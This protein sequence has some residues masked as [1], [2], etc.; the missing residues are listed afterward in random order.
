MDEEKTT[1]TQDTTET[2]TSETSES[3]PEKGEQSIDLAGLQKQLDGISAQLRK[4]EVD[5]ALLEKVDAGIQQLAEMQKPA[6]SLD[7]NDEL[8]QKVTALQGQVDAGTH[9]LAVQKI[10]TK[11][12]LSASEFDLIETDDLEK[13]ETRATNLREKVQLANRKQAIEFP[14]HVK[15][16][17]DAERIYRQMHS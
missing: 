6:E 2:T 12:N 15:G 3:T 1:E 5:P 9:A 10:V 11:H 16:N 7:P 17:E 14:D 4:G 13:L 8:I